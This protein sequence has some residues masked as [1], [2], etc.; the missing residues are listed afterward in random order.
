MIHRSELYDESMDSNGEVKSL[1][2]VQKRWS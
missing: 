2:A 1:G